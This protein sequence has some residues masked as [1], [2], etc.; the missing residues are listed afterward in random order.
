MIGGGGAPGPRNYTDV[1]YYSP[2][3][4][5]DGDEPA[6]RP[7]ITDAPNRIG[8]DGTFEIETRRRRSPG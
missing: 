8:Y 3:Y 6:V 1:E 5:F 2:S 4:L 7:E